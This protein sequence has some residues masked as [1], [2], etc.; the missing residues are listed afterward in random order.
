M[1]SEIFHIHKVKNML[2]SV[3]FVHICGTDMNEGEHLGVHS[4]A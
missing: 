4:E 3:S 2:F 1:L